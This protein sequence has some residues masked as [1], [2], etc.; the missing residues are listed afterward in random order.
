[1]LPKVTCERLGSRVIAG[2][3]ATTSCPSKTVSVPLCAVEPAAR[4]A[5]AAPDAPIP[6]PDGGA[7]GPPDAAAPDAPRA[8]A[9]APDASTRL[10]AATDRGPAPDASRPVV[11]ARPDASTCEPRPSCPCPRPAEACNQVDDDCDGEIDEGCP[12]AESVT[13]TDGYAALRGFHAPCMGAFSDNCL[14]ASSRYCATRT[15]GF[16]VSGY[17]PTT[18]GPAPGTYTVTCVNANLAKAV[19]GTIAQLTPY[20]ARCAGP[21]QAPSEPCVRA[22]HA[23]C[24]ANGH[25]AGFGPVEHMLDTVVFVCVN[26]A[27]LLTRPVA[28]L[29]AADAGCNHRSAA[30]SGPCLSAYHRLC[31]EQGAES[32]FGPTAVDEATGEITFACLPR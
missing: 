29:A 15:P 13:L 21:N 11:D 31:R 5:G 16:A 28:A 32:G 25:A 30:F 6:A 27:Q 20:D 18:S 12:L 9:R 1:V 8:D 17:G 3:A 24:R 2:L 14:S 26:R 19:S 22:M 4:D 7:L 10:D 23:Y